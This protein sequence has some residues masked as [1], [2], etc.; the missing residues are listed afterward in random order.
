MNCKPGDL[1]YIVRADGVPQAIGAVVEVV[2]KGR[3]VE[4]M[5]A[6]HVQVSER[7]TVSDKRTGKAAYRNRVNIPD[8]WLRPISGVPVEDERCDEVT[9]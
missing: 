5:P 3:D 1:A 7:Y 4:S 2:Q 8:A 9:K 6:W